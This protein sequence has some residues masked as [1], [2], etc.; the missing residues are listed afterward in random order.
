MNQTLGRGNER[1]REERESTGWPNRPGGQEHQEIKRAVSPEWLGCRRKSS[2]REGSE[3]RGAGE[4]VS[5]G[6]DKKF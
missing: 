1:G 5:G 3:A 4:V 2:W 6:W